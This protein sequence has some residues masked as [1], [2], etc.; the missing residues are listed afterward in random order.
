MS[1]QYIVEDAILGAA[2]FWPFVA[3][4]A[5]LGEVPDVVQPPDG[6]GQQL[7]QPRPLLRDRHPVQGHTSRHTAP[8]E[9]A[10]TTCKVNFVSK[11]SKVESMMP[12]TWIELR[13]PRGDVM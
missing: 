5:L 10:A 7:H 2:T 11:A 4:T 3:Q 13:I 12:H 8:E 9:A 6:R 1:G